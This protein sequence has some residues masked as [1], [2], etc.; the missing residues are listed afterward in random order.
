M[1]NVIQKNSVPATGP[2]LTIESMQARVD[3]DAALEG[4]VPD[5]VADYI[6][7]QIDKVAIFI[8]DLCWTFQPQP[9]KNILRVK[10]IR[11]ANIGLNLI[12]AT[13]KSINA[14]IKLYMMEAQEC[15]SL[16]EFIE[17]SNSYK[18][19]PVY[20]VKLNYMSLMSSVKFLVQWLKFQFPDNNMR[21]KFVTDLHNWI[22][23]KDSKKG[24]L[25]LVGKA[26]FGKTQIGLSLVCLRGPYGTIR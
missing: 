22:N 10:E 3:I 6:Y 18:A 25:A 23:Q 24:I 17:K 15:E 8:R 11:A 14:G 12:S 13:D 4:E 21:C 9:A 26:S 16:E 7:K 5:E 1:D 2:Q 20:H 19:T